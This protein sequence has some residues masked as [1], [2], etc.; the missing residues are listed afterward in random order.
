MAGRK[1]GRGR[2]EACIAGFPPVGI[3]VRAAAA[4]AA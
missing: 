4:R 1:A 3:G 2:V